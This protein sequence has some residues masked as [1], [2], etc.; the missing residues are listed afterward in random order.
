MEEARRNL[1]AYFDLYN[2]E[3]PH[4]ALAYRTPAEVHFGV[5]GR[6]CNNVT[7]VNKKEKE[8]KRKKMLLLQNTTLKN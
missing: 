8:A 7:G 1:G 5:G 4:Q 6:R 3:R 2:Q